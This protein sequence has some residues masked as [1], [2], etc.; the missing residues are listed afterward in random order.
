MQDTGTGIPPEIA[1]RVF[2]QF[3]TTKAV[4]AGTGQGLSLRAGGMPSP[5]QGRRSSGLGRRRT[6]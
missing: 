3:F 1:D 4:R 5:G 2:E 6:R